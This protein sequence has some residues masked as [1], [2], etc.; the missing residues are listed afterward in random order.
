MGRKWS[1]KMKTM[2]KMMTLLAVVGMV[3]AL[4]PAAQAA[5]IALTGAASTAGPGTDTVNYPAS[6]V[7]DASYMASG[8]GASGQ[9]TGTTYGGWYSSAITTWFRVDLGASYDVGTMYVW[10]GQPGNGVWDRGVGSADI[11]YSTSDTAQAIPT[12]GATSGDWI[13]ITAA[14]AFNPKANAT[15][16]YGYTDAF[17]LNVTGAWVIGLQCT[18]GF[19]GNG[20]NS[21]GQLQFD[22]VITVGTLIMVE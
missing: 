17:D 14:Q 18:Q 3:F 12:G 11:Y 7:T 15:V 2:K 16:N 1:S 19:G 6:R 13:L 21:L 10:N 5:I 22:G 20:G 4:A 9:M 8:S